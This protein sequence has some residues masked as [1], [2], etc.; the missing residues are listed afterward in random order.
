MSLHIKTALTL[1]F[2]ITL[3]IA[4]LAIWLSWRDRHDFA[5][6][7]RREISR[8]LLRGTN[9][10]RAQLSNLEFTTLDWAV[11]DD[12]FDYAKVPNQPFEQSM[13]NTTKFGLLDL[14]TILIQDRKTQLLFGQERTP[15]GNYR[16]LPF[17]PKIQGEMAR[18][19]DTS[20]W[21]W[22][23]EAQFIVTG[24]FAN[25]EGKLFLVTTSPIIP[26]S[27]LLAP[28]GQLTMARI[29]DT[30][31]ITR[32]GEEVQL[33]LDLIPPSSDKNLPAQMLSQLQ[34][35][36]AEYID[37]ASS[38]LAVGY[39]LLSMPGREPP[40]VLRIEFAREIYGQGM[41]SIWRT[42]ASLLGFTALLLGLVMWLLERG[43]LS[44]LTH[45]VRQLSQ[46]GD[47][48]GR[49]GVEGDDELGLLAHSLNTGLERIERTQVRAARAE[50]ELQRLRGNELETLV[51]ERTAELNAVQF[52]MLERLA[53]VAEFRDDDI[54]AHTRRVS[55]LSVILAEH[56]GVN[57][58]DCSRL[59]FAARLHDIGKI[60]I[61]D[62]ILFKPSKL[63]PEEWA[64]MQTHAAVGAQMLDHSKS[65][66]LTMAHQVALTHHERW[67]GRR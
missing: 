9:V 46:S 19:Y 32:L 13:L 53:A 10:I 38:D 55:E 54:G 24:G 12:L 7:E 47:A 2:A 31:A 42:V 22:Q 48:T 25:Y 5:A 21:L 39:R 63:D 16:S 58:E 59:S 1:G 66:I 50:A 34:R 23:R 64:L 52:E 35:E 60:A 6:L 56:L 26:S 36:G 29:L 20:Q 8:D 62:A 27:R 61:P 3:L 45:S 28:S 30:S 4:L 44:R 49:V 37:F 40:L 41:A 14:E 11:W 18:L 51:G 65:E 33:K 15:I 17:A 67:D 43:L 57:P